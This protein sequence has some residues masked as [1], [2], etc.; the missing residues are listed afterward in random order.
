MDNRNF[1]LFQKSIFLIKKYFISIS[2]IIS[3]GSNSPRPVFIP[4]R[5][6]N[7]TNSLRNLKIRL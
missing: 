6:K 4:L 7:P 5:V 3:L 1:N 2:N